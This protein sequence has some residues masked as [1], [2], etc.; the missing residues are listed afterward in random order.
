[1]KAKKKSLSNEGDVMLIEKEI[2][3]LLRELTNTEQAQIHLNGFV[4]SVN[5]CDKGSQLLL[6]TPV[7][8]G[9]NYIPNSVRCSLNKKAP[10]NRLEIPTSLEVDEES[11][12]ISLKY[13][14]Y[15]SQMGYIGI[16]DLLE[17]FS[18]LAERWRDYLDEQ[19]KNDL[20][21]VPVK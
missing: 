20:I 4:V 15:P 11:F 3:R 9:G 1:M 8:H 16:V 6:T 21:Y 14:G 2:N 12:S 13:N 5:M 18:W 10:F 17:D 7:Y 19:D